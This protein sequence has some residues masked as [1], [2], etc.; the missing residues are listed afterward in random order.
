MVKVTKTS[1]KPIKGSKAGVNSNVRKTSASTE[2]SSEQ[3]PVPRDPDVRTHCR[4]D[5]S[6]NHPKKRPFQKSQKEKLEVN[7]DVVSN[8]QT[9]LSRNDWLKTHPKKIWCSRYQN[10]IQTTTVKTKVIS[11][12]MTP[13][14]VICNIGNST[15]DAEVKSTTLDTG[16]ASSNVGPV[17][18]LGYFTCRTPAQLLSLNYLRIQNSIKCSKSFLSYLNFSGYILQQ[19][20]K[21]QYLNFDGGLVVKVQMVFPSD[22]HFHAIWIMDY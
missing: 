5:W 15:S 1:N 12:T 9:S 10:S 7:N 18:N 8:F 19:M 21:S 3:T 11:N 2:N 6:T 13:S 4:N 16:N 22:N 14:V 17:T 20:V